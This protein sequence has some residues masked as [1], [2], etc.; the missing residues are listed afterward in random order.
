MLV[1]DAVGLV[2]EGAALELVRPVVGQAQRV[3]VRQGSA[4]PG[5]GGAGRGVQAVVGS[6]RHWACVLRR[7]QRGPCVVHNALE[8]FEWHGSRTCSR[9]RAPNGSRLRCSG[10]SPRAGLVAKVHVV[11]LQGAAV[12]D[13]SM[14]QGQPISL[15]LI[16]SQCKRPA[17]WRGACK[18][19]QVGYRFASSSSPPPHLVAQVHVEVVKGVAGGARHKVQRAR[20]LLHQHK[21]CGRGQ[22][23]RAHSICKPAS[24]QPALSQRVL[25]PL[26]Q[27][28]LGTKLAPAAKARQR[29]AAHPRSCS[30]PTW[31][32]W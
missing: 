30:P 27:S 18:A 32:T 21:A 9:K 11:H 16:A 10:A 28:I 19:R 22:W 12:R 13:D 17:R 1:G 5:A 20:H 26:E 15:E 6:L 8:G 31:P 29:S 14:E 4:P 23:R 24:C 7:R 2:G 3:H 25:E